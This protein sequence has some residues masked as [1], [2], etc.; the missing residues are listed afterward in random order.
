MRHSLNIP[1]ATPTMDMCLIQPHSQAV[2]E[3]SA[4]WGR[5]RAG[6]GRDRGFDQACRATN[7]GRNC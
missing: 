2:P 1:A 4:K 3:A 6:R 7:H 5:A